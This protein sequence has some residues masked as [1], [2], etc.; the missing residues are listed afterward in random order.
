[1]KLAKKI[2][3]LLF[4]ALSL[5]VC[6]FINNKLSSNVSR[7]QILYLQSL[8]EKKVLVINELT[9]QGITAEEDDRG[10]LVIIDLNIRYEFDETG[11]EYIAINKG[12][13][14]PQSDYKME[15]YKITLGQFSGIDTIQLIYSM[16]DLD[17]GKKRFWGDLPIKETN[18]RL[19]Q[20]VASNEE[21]REVVKKAE[22]YEKRIK[23]ILETI[24]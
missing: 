24:K 7:Q 14:K 22:R 8:R 15:I 17:N 23:K 11:I 3:F 12:W 2:V 5:A 1:M 19:K 6:L 18:Q 21:I 20:E 4:L 10:K 16:K 9:K 13:I